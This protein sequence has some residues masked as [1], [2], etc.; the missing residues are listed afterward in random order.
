MC[1]SGVV[2]GAPVAG[3]P[4]SATDPAGREGTTDAGAGAGAGAA[5]APTTALMVALYPDLSTMVFDR[6]VALNFVFVVDR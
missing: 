6:D 4:E 3:A 2:T 1:M 5:T